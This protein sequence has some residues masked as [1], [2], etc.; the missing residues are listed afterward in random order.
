MACYRDSLTEMV[1]KPFVM[2]LLVNQYI[3]GNTV[4]YLRVLFYI[5]FF[6]Y[7][8]RFQNW[9]TENANIS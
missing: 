9:L 1:D 5:Q 2:N 4:T 3:N 8:L 6:T 7:K